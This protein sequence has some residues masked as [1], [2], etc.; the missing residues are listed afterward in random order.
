MSI[1][2]LLLWVFLVVLR[3]AC[4]C[5]CVYMCVMEI[6]CWH[7][8]LTLSLVYWLDG[9]DFEGHWISAVVSCVSASDFF[10]SNSLVQLKGI[11]DELHCSVYLFSKPFLFLKKPQEIHNQKKKIVICKKVP[12]PAF[13]TVAFDPHNL[14]YFNEWCIWE[15]SLG[16]WFTLLETSMKLQSVWF[17]EVSQKH[18]LTE[19]KWWWGKPGGQI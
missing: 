4:V 11:S 9:K 1:L 8:L 14:M 7:L 3:C 18:E 2:T 6:H 17:Q 13:R 16:I 5:L 15:M 12:K 19:R 10:C